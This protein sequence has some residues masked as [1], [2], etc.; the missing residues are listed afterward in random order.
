VGLSF[1]AFGA[2][3]GA[4]HVAVLGNARRAGVA[5][6]VGVTDFFGYRDSDVLGAIR[7]VVP[8]GYDFIVDS[9]GQRDS[10]NNVLPALKPHGA[11]A[12]YGIDEFHEQRINPGRARGGFV[13]YTGGYD[14]AETHQRVVEM[15]LQGRLDARHWLNLDSPYPLDAIAEAFAAL[16]RRELVKALIRIR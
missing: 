1:A 12:I 10:L 5:H 14:E 8:V 2:L 3:L 13:F 11:A 6:D 9:V 16:E 15:A 4:Q 7:T